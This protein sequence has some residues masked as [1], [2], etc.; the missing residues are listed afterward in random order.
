MQNKKS[1]I[2]TLQFFLLSFLLICL[3]SLGTI[4]INFF[5]FKSTSEEN[6]VKVSELI[7]LGVKDRYESVN[8]FI[9]AVE[10]FVTDT[11]KSILF[12][13]EN[14]IQS[15]GTVDNLALENLKKEYNVTDIYIIN[16]EGFVQFSTDKNNIGTN[17]S[18]LYQNKKDIDWNEIFK[19]V[20]ENK[21]IYVDKFSQSREYP[22][23]F[24]K[25][26]YKGVGYIDNVGFV[27]LEI[28]LS[29]SDIKDES[30]ADLIASLEKLDENDENIIQVSFEN[31]PPGKNN[32]NYFK[33]SKYKVGNKYYTKM[34]AVN[35]NDEVSQITVVTK[36][37]E[38]DR[39][40]TSS[41]YNAIIT[42]VFIFLFTVIVSILFYY[43]FSIPT[44]S[45]SHKEALEKTI[46][47]LKKITENK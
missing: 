19:N 41:F 21:E 3:F 14:K 20:Q 47:E 22:Y 15:L 29:I 46:Q 1:K 11:M 12:S 5:Q 13:M 10:P 37:D 43:R 24:T 33:E 38:V 31:S 32:S 28:S 17:T 40:V 8:K 4:W 42:S 6:S 25:L 7:T 44:Q 27:V 18:S 16:N 35:L 45:N 2:K 9:V 23:D 36:F 26:A 34:N 39:T 30:V